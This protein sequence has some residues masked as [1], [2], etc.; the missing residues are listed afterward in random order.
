MRKIILFIFLSFIWFACDSQEKIHTIDEFTDA[1]DVYEIP[2]GTYFWDEFKDI[3]LRYNLTE[4]E[5]KLLG[6]WFN[7][8]FGKDIV[9]NYYTFFPNKLF[10]LKFYPRNIRIV[11]SEKMYFNKA[12]GTWEIKNNIVRI[13]IYAII[14]EDD[15]MKYPNNKGLFL[16]D[17]P[18]SIDFIN[19]DDIDEQGFTRRP[20]NDT[21]LSRE[22]RQKVTIKEPNRTNN[23]YV[24]NVYTIDVITNSGKPEKNYGY[25]SIVPEMAQKNLS[26]LDVATDPELIEKYIFRLWP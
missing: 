21:I 11:D 23:L 4:N 24:R 10:L 8:T 16:V 5:S 14:T 26:G 19:I 13:T 17:K 22:L 25:F 6:E 15:T 7:V 2:M 3:E 20:I 12:L 1:F 9:N 18:Y